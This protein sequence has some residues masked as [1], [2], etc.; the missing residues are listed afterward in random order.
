GDAA[1]A[2]RRLAHVR[3]EQVVVAATILHEE[4]LVV[5]GRAEGAIL[6][7][8]RREARAGGAPGV[9]DAHAPGAIAVPARDV[10]IAARLNHEVAESRSAQQG[11]A[12]IDCVSLPDATEMHAH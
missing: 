1:T 11:R 8:E 7:V 2:T 6:E 4:P 9:P 5:P 12:A 10:E 3:I